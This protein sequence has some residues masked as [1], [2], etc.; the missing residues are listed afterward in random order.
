MFITSMTFSQDELN[1]K[2]QIAA[3]KVAF[4]TS[5]MQLSPDEA[6]VFWPVYDQYEKQIHGLREAHRANVRSKGKDLDALSDV[7]VE[8]LIDEEMEIKEEELE[9]R[10]KMHTEL[11]KLVGPRKVAM[12]YK[13]EKEFHREL[14]QRYKQGKHRSEMKR[15][16]EKRSP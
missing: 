4:I 1:K 16:E 14:L 10:K 7:E 12:L 6:K 3:Q 13:A 2:E 15:S 8:A 11:K 5:R 9:V